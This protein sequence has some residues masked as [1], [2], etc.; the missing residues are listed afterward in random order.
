VHLDHLILPVNDLDASRDFYTRLLGFTDEGP[1]GP[2]HAV[3]VDDFLILL[4]PFGTEGG[5]HLAFAVDHDAFD[6]AFA[7]LQDAGVPYGF[8]FDG[9]GNM[10]G[11][12]TE[13]GARG[14]ETSIYFNDPNGHLLELLYYGQ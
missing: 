9:V 8:P 10:A 12:G 11:P 13:R 3:R 14:K 5:T 1:D 2:F 7:R 6:A 4:A